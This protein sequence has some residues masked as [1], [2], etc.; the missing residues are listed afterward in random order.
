MNAC[1]LPKETGRWEAPPT[2]NLE[3]L[4]DTAPDLHAVQL[5]FVLTW[6]M[7]C[8][9]FLLHFSPPHLPA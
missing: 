2:G 3:R 7:R 6:R 4:P 9:L 1:L 5:S 8:V